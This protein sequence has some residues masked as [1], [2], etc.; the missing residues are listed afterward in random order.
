VTT[1]TMPA[2]LDLDG[3]TLADVRAGGLGDRPVTISDGTPAMGVI[4]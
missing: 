2:T 4:A 3:L 1:M